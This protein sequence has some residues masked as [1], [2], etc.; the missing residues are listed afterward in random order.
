MKQTYLLQHSIFEYASEHAV[1]CW[2]RQGVAPV[3]AKQT[4][5]ILPCMLGHPP[6]ERDAW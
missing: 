4:P 3:S 2:Q 5:A 1:I 6:K